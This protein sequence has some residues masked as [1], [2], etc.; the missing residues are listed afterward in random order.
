MSNPS[1]LSII[2]HCRSCDSTEFIPLFKFDPVPLAGDFCLTYNEAINA[3]KY[4]ISFV[5]NKESGL[6]QSMESIDPNTLFLKYKYDSSTIPALVKHF[7]GLATELKIKFINHQN[8]KLLEVGSNSNPLLNQLPLQWELTAVDPSDVAAR[9]SRNSNIRL[10][11]DFFSS[12]F[13]DKNG[14]IGKYDCLTG[15]N[16][17][18]HMKNLRDMFLAVRLALKNNGL[19]Y[20]EVKDGDTILNSGEGADCY[21]EHEIL[22]CIDSLKHILSKLGFEYQSH[23]ILPFHGGLIRACFK[24][25]EKTEIIPLPDNY[26]TKVTERA[27]NIQSFY[28][29]LDNHPIT[30]ELKKSPNNI[31]FGASGKATMTLNMLKGVRFSYIV[32]ESPLKIGKFI[33]GTGVPIVGPQML[34][35]PNGGN[36]ILVTAYNYYDSIIERYKNTGTFNWLKYF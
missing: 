10:F 17:F 33:P 11:N 30:Q 15:S 32:D 35:T 18:A 2:Q 9:A 27:K 4:P 26:F 5:V 22:H 23:Q 31:A 13:V 24:K 3:P 28:D 29:N 25:V 16:V 12:D 14:M 1:P 20:I 36:N 34:R 7:E 8:I 21:L 6:I 19:F